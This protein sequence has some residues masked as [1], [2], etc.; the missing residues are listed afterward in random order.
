MTPEQARRYR[1]AL[2]DFRE[3]LRL[4]AVGAS[5]TAQ[6]EQLRALVWEFPDEARTFLTEYEDQERRRA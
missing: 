1:A 4:P 2:A 5:R 3:A 6:I